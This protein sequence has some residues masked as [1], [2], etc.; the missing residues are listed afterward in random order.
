MRQKIILLNI[1][2]LII[3]RN[4]ALFPGGVLDLLSKTSDTRIVVCYKKGSNPNL[5]YSGKNVILEEIEENTQKTFLQRT[6]HFFYSYLIF[7]RTTMLVSSY[8]VRA[9]KP[10]PLWKYFNFPL[11]WLL[12]QTFGRVRWFRE[13]FVPTLYHWIFSARP[14]SYLF[15]KYQPDLVFLPNICL[16]PNDLELMAEAKRQGVKIVGMPGNW[17]HLSKYYIPLKPDWL[18][19]W[20]DQVKKEALQYQ[21]YRPEIISIVGAPQADFFLDEKNLLSRE[22]FLK[23]VGFPANA[24]IITYGSQGPYSLDGQDYIDIVMKAVN[25]GR[26]PSETRIIIR[27][28]PSSVGQ[29]ELEKYEPFFNHPIVYIDKLE[30]WSSTDNAKNYC[31]IL[32]HADVVMT[33]FSSVATDASLYD[34]PVV[35]CSF[36]G[37]RKRPLWQSVRRHKNF[38]HFRNVMATGGV[39]VIEK[40]E[41][42]IPAIR[43][44]LDSP[45]KD[46]AGRK[47]LREDVFGF[48]DRRNAERIVKEIVKH[49]A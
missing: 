43:E 39:R 42:L 31:N 49:L 9:D 11:K 17:D 38:T 16:W 36:D 30:G 34:R 3:L 15:Q 37:Y 47:R 27:P 6:F 26:L 20:S 35:I 13:N 40:K 32:K 10:R 25:D 19:V 5:A 22:E 2:N 14:Y 21:Y 8:G 28:H 44:Y 7:T 12:A 4:I 33:T 46:H 41:N 29:R 45:T 1:T 48:T 24:K 18:L 23:K